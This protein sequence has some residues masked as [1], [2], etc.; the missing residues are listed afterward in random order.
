[1]ANQYYSPSGNPP[2]NGAGASASIRAEFAAISA[3]F[4]KLPSTTGSGGRLVVVD[5][6]GSALTFAT[7]ITEV[8]TTVTFSGLVVF[9]GASVSLPA[10]TTVNSLPVATTTGTQT[11]TNKT[12]PSPTISAPTVTGGTFA[13]PTLTSPAVSAPTFSGVSVFQ[14]ALQEKYNALPGA[15]IDLGLGSV[16]SVTVSGPV[17]LSVSNPAAAG[18]SSAFVL[19]VTNG[20]SATITWWPGVKWGGGVAPTLTTAGV[21]LL[22]FYTRDGGLTW[23]GLVLARDSK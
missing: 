15:N 8:G 23:R 19:E 7:T 12:L 21:D 9:T 13:T 5:P 10:N 4:D 3:G 17:T 20:G 16:F 1:M 14:G 6:S 11:L 22:G 18:S 2:T